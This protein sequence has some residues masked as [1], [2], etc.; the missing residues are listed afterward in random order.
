MENPKFSW[1]IFRKKNAE[2]PSGIRLRHRWFQLRGFVGEL[3]GR[4]SRFGSRTSVSGCSFLLKICYKNNLDES[5]I[6]FLYHLYRYMLLLVFYGNL[7]EPQKS[8]HML[9][10]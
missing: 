2:V 4:W 7:D 3:W 1:M 9:R 5:Y 8:N 10:V 6:I